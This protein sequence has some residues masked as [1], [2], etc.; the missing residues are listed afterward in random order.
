MLYD[1]MRNWAM[2]NCTKWLILKKMPKKGKDW[3][4][5][6]CPERQKIDIEKDAQKGKMIDMKKDS[7]MKK[8]CDEK[9]ENGLPNINLP[10]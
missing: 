7:Q 4:W 8:E 2:W 1:E 9:D 5:K 10:I 3:Y 6:R